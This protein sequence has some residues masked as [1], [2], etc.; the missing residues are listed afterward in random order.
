MKRNIFCLFLLSLSFLFITCAGSDHST[1]TDTGWVIGN[2]TDED[3]GI[4]T[5]KILKTS[6]GGATWVLQ[7]LPVECDDFMA[8]TSAPSTIRWRGQPLPIR[9]PTRKAVFYTQPTAAESGR[10]RAFLPE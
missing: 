5:V 6:N 9:T 4:S 2:V 1:A 7:T 3:T 8:T 10:S